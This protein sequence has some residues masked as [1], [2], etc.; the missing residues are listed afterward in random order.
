M[1]E[2]FAFIQI[3][4]T[5]PNPILDRI[6][7]ISLSVFNKSL[8]HRETYSTWLNPEKKISEN[9]ETFLGISNRELKSYPKFIEIHSQI[10]RM[11]RGK[12]LGMF[13]SETKTLE[14]LK[15]ELFNV[16][17]DYKYKNSDL[18]LVKDIEEALQGKNIEHMYFKYYD[19]KLP[20]NFDYTKVIGE[21]FKQQCILLNKDFDK[22]DIKEVIIKDFYN[23]S[24]SYVYEKDSKLF[25]N[26]GRHKDKDV[27]TV[28]K[29]YIEW[30]LYNEFPL[31]TKKLI[32]DY[33]KDEQFN[34][35][36]FKNY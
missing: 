28:N 15:E 18:I 20:E 13:S 31:K 21:I 4:S 30:V 16:G 29:N 23:I 7:Y 35:D 22:F 12:K 6:C 32:V 27:A 1:G 19:S 9:F 17:I 5:G 10:M 26:F 11:I 2:G 3:I 14:F 8:N 25:F 33:L 34:I 36:R 24:E